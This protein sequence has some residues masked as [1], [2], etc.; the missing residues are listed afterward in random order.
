MRELIM[1]A[2]V[3]KANFSHDAS[4]ANVICIIAE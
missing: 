4:K 3:C 1:L 2:L